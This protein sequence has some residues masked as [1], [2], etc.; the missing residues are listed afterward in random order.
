MAT[1]RTSVGDIKYNRRVSN[2]FQAKHV[3]TYN[4]STP[5]IRPKDKNKPK[6]RW[7]CTREIGSGAF[8][9]VYQTEQVEDV[10][11]SIP[12]GAALKVESGATDT[13]LL[14]AEHKVLHAMQ[15]TSGFAKTYYFEDAAQNGGYN[16]VSKM[17][18]KSSKGSKVSGGPDR[19]K[20]DTLLVTE[21]LGLDLENIKGSMGN[22]AGNES[23]GCSNGTIGN[24][25]IQC[26]DRL[27]A[28]HDKGI[29]HKDVKAENFM[30]GRSG[31]RHQI[32]LIDFGLCSSY[33]IG[34]TTNHIEMREDRPLMG[35]VRYASMNGHRGLEMSRRDDMEALAYVLIYL[36]VGS[37]PWQV[38]N[39]VKNNA[40]FK[41]RVKEIKTDTTVG[42][43]CPDGKCHPG[44]SQFLELSRK[45]GFAD[46]PDYDA[47]KAL[48]TPE[49]AADLSEFDSVIPDWCKSV[50]PMG[51][52]ADPVPFDPNCADVRELARSNDLDV[53]GFDL[54]VK[55]DDDASSVSSAEMSTMASST[56][57][58]KKSLGQ[59]TLGLSSLGLSKYDGGG[60]AISRTARLEEKKKL[61]AETK[62]LR[63]DFGLDAFDASFKAMVVVVW[64]FVANTETIGDGGKITEVPRRETEEDFAFPLVLLLAIAWISVTAFSLI[65]FR[66]LAEMRFV[67]EHGYSYKWKSGDRVAGN[68]SGV[69]PRIER[70]AKE[71]AVMHQKIRAMQALFVDL[72]WVICNVVRGASSESGLGALGTASIA[73]AGFGFGMKF[74]NVIALLKSGTA[75]KVA[76]FRSVPAEVRVGTGSS[77]NPDVQAAVTFCWENL[78]AEIGQGRTPSLVL[79]FMTANHDHAKGLE[80]FKELSA[81]EKGAFPQFSGCTL[82]WGAMMGAAHRKKDDLFCVGMWAIFDPEGLYQLGHADLNEVNEKE[83]VT[84]KDVAKRAARSANSARKKLAALRPENPVV[85]GK[86]DFLWMNPPP[87][88]EDSVIEGITLGLRR[89]GGIDII[90]GSSADNDVT[91]KWKQWSSES[92][93]TSN[94]VQFVIASC[95]AQVKGCAFT[96][97]NATPK[98][99]KVTEVLGPRHIKTID[100]RPA[101]TVYNEW[102]SGH[103][104]A[105]IE[106]LTQDS[107]ILG[108]SSVYPLGQIVGYDHEGEPCYRT[109]HPHLIKKEDMS[110]TLFSDVA[111]GQDIVNMAGTKENIEN[112]ISNTALHIQ[113]STGIPPT[114]F[115]GALVVFCAGAMMY[116]G[117]GMNTA[118]RKLDEALGGCSYLGIHT[119]GE[120]GP[121]PDGANR[122]G[123]LMFSALVV[124]S[125]RKI[126]K[127]QNVDKEEVVYETDERFEDIAMSGGI[128]GGA[129]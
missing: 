95:S 128:L 93:I 123:N 100:G 102:T 57:A 46:K 69:D 117:D 89:D 110:L 51:G 62:A 88:V 119:F 120:Q 125:R 81:D 101:A 66:Q 1:R 50:Q 99:G 58:D 49:V 47:M 60:D 28:L 80:K 84:A 27:Q 45:L 77:T 71:R 14:A 30:I 73:V 76:M 124:T 98:L 18:A 39:E 32:Y 19:G 82:C 6:C 72:P 106:D 129:P 96:G 114:E 53:T 56:E 5:V 127:L 8:G 92:G 118:C 63:F 42:E 107:V 4:P 33:Y 113:R 116:C 54:E 109:M 75:A 2:A 21:L 104:K 126:M 59:S 43:L 48:F 7:T 12:K 97:Y 103:F 83:K 25:A 122:H 94:G 67:A 41:G 115:R 87:G 52:S 112:R 37:L 105:E 64:M 29:L 17:S 23:L 38:E 55:I 111:V 13:P 20:Q 3:A 36:S 65:R 16:S 35:T 78:T 61:V 91:G 9:L 11:P 108:P 85:Q 121:F 70:D 15:G 10:D 74:S 24:I 22:A 44:L 79:I 34:G 90:G 31:N 68:G 40:H 26:I 86:P